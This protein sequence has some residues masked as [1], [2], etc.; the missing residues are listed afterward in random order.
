MVGTV[1]TSPPSSPFVENGMIFSTTQP[2][3]SANVSPSGS[4]S[5]SPSPKGGLTASNEANSTNLGLMRRK[6]DSLATVFLP[7][8]LTF[9]VCN[10]PRY[11]QRFFKEIEFIDD[12]EKILI[13]LE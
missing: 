8:I 13:F 6:E 10:F 11:W 1:F 9:L 2:P 5:R 4:L 7:I 12:F 3:Y